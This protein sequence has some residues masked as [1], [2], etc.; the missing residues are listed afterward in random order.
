MEDQVQVPGEAAVDLAIEFEAIPSFEDA[1]NVV[2]AY[3]EED[4]Y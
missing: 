3:R 4:W 2:G 1:Y